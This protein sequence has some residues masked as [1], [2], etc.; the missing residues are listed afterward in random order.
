MGDIYLSIL[1]NNYDIICLTET[2]FDESVH[3]GE[4]IDGRYNVFRRDRS[5][6]RSIK[7]DGGG[8]LVAVKM[9][10]NIIRRPSWKSGVEDIWLTFPPRGVPS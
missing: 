7:Q 8:V 6:S 10:I 5:S 2:N 9:H 1:G 3:D 4:F